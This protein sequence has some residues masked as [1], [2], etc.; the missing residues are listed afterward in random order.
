M[1]SH[2]KAVAGKFVDV[3]K[4]VQTFNSDIIR[5]LLPTI[6][7]ISLCNICGTFLLF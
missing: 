5:N 7:S 3:V 2:V 6:I 4:F 1:D